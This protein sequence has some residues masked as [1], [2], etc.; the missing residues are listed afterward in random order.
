MTTRKKQRSKAKSKCVNVRVTAR[1]ACLIAAVSGGCQEIRPAGQ[2]DASQAAPSNPLVQY[3]VRQDES[4]QQSGDNESRQHERAEMIE[5]QMRS[6]GIKDERVLQAINAVPRHLFVPEE[7]A[8]DAYSDH[9]LPI[10]HDQTISQP[11]IVALMTELVQ[12]KANHKA[13]DVGTGSGYQAAVLAM[14]VDH[15]YS[16][17]I[18]EPLAQSA[19]K[20]LQELKIDNV[21]V[22]H[23]DGYDGWPEEAPFDVIILAAAPRQI[24]QPLID[25]LAVGGRLVLPVG[26]SMR[27]TLVLI[28]KQE[29][30]SIIKKEI[31]PV[32]FVPMTGKT[33]DDSDDG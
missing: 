10:G 4:E 30:G 14:L 1:W 23:G 17:E 8:R 15:V 22:R 20:R 9:P 33:E 5:S 32:A 29:D 3:P 6:R 21:T 26:E 19:G 16:I 31:I 7:F 13:L 28:E 27:Q 18:V 25:Q 24:P 11:Y 2:D 12:P